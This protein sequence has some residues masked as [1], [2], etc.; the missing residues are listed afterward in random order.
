MGPTYKNFMVGVQALHNSLVSKDCFFTTTGQFALQQIV[1]THVDI[2]SK[3]M[4][5]LYEHKQK[6]RNGTAEP[7]KV[8][9]FFFENLKCKYSNLYY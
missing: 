9:I 5:Y 3:V 7:F 6:V 4:K 2:G 8:R 1:Y